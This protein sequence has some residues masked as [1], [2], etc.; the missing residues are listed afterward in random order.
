VSVGYIEYGGLVGVSRCQFERTLRGE[1]CGRDGVV[2]R[3]GLRLCARHAERL[4]LEERLN[5]WRAI[6]AHVELW[7]REAA[8]RGRADVVGLLQ[9]EREEASAELARASEG[10]EELDGGRR[11]EGGSGDGRAPPPWPPL[12]LLGLCLL[13]G[14]P[15]LGIDGVGGRHP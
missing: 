1:I 15:Y 10:L 13:L 6:L 11:G 2:G 8:G 12:L 9:A 14:I 7:S 4:R 5:Y 3:G